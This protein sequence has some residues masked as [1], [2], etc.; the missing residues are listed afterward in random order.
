MLWQAVYEMEYKELHKDEPQQEKL[1][2]STFK[3]KLKQRHQSRK[4]T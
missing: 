1:T 2:A 3:D 4:R